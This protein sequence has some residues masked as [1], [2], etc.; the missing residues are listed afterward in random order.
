M[1]RIGF[2]KLSALIVAAAL[3]PGLAQE[4]PAAGA[5]KEGKPSEE[6][7]M[8]RWQ[9]AMTPGPAHK[10]LEPLIGEWQLE[11]RFWMAGPDAPPMEA[12]GTT[13]SR[14]IL[15]GRFVQED[16]SS[17]IMGMPF[18]GLGTTGYDNLKKK[19]VTTWMD[20]M[21]T[22]IS[23]SEGT[24]DSDGKVFTFHGKM[25]DAMTGEKDKPFKYILRILSAD[26]HIFEM[27]DVKLGAKS[28]V[29]ELTYTR[30]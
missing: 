14:W 15:G 9:E 19:Y 2:A 3:C 25:D 18:Q 8:K 28:K 1:K 24:A 7:M 10:A 12:K 22:G 4:K 13:K 20:N 26:K 30:K 27:H 16:V 29:G 23:T 21:T 17:E 11:T 6:E 5:S